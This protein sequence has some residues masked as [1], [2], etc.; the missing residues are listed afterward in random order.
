MRPS[1]EI[2]ELYGGHNTQHRNQGALALY[3]RLGFI[4]QP[5][6]LAVLERHLA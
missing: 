3:E 1:V 5:D 2:E 4:R 6:G